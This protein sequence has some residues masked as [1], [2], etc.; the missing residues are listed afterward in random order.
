MQIPFL[1]KTEVYYE[2]VISSFEIL[3]CEFEQCW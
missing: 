1:G 2:G 3:A